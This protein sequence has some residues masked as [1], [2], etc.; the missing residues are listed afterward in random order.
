MKIN[1]ITPTFNAAK[2]IG[3]TADSIVQISKNR[4]DLDIEWVILDNNSADN[5][6]EILES[7]KYKNLN[8]KLI[9]EQDKGIYD[10]MNKGLDL[11]NQGHVL[12]LGAGDKILKLPKNLE[13]QN[14]YYGTTIV[15]DERHYISSIDNYVFNT[16][17]SLH[18]QSMLTPISFHRHFNTNYK[19]CADYAHNIEMLIDGRTFKFD[20]D[21]LSYHLPDGISSN[22][23][24]VQKECQ[25]IQQRVYE[26]TKVETVNERI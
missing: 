26:L 3:Q 18:H 2:Y 23:I 6:A 1:I 9:I 7:Q 21:L 15:E 14:V 24:N 10:A 19:I 12:F 13:D 11:C 16:F 20:P 4:S 22:L 8:Y 17:N 5:I 25:V